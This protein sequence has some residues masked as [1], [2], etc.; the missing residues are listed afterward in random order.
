[1]G[2][3]SRIGRSGE[4]EDSMMTVVNAEPSLERIMHA[5]SVALV[6]A[7]AT[8]KRA[9]LLLEVAKASPEALRRAR[10]FY[11]RARERAERIS[12]SLGELMLDFPV[13]DQP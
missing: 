7:K 3:M 6:T 13:G 1:M 10:G 2:A 12:R 4:L 8:E 9:A 5:M 11:V